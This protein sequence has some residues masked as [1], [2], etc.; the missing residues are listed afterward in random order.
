[1]VRTPHATLQ[2]ITEA[3]AEATAASHA[4][5]LALDGDGLVAIVAVGTDAGQAAGHV[6]RAGEGS[7]GYVLASGQP[8][9][10]QPR[11]GDAHPWADQHPLLRRV[12]RSILAVP[13]EA[14]DGLV[15]VLE[16]VDAVSGSFSFDD[17]EVVGLLG[18]IAGAA[19]AEG[20]RHG[21][22]DVAHPD[23]LGRELAQ[24]FADDP[25]RY[26]RIAVVLEALLSD[27]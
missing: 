13:C 20:M 9:A 8:L 4:W 6:I 10:L 23:Q 19:L 17:V 15:G 11:P 21:P 22:R 24:I 26:A 14:A 3:A 2:A 18:S 1:M 12:P 7:T 16:L 5:L 25:S 27:G